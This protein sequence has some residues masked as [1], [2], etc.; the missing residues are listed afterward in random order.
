MKSMFARMLLPP[1]GDGLYPTTLVKLTLG[2]V[3]LD[4]KVPVPH[5]MATPC[6]I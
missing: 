1:F 6:H 5:V 2:F 4:M 3:K